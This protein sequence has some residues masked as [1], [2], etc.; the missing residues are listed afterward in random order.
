IEA[1]VVNARFIAPFDAE[2]ARELAGIPAV[3]LEDHQISGGL[4]AALDETLGG[5]PHAPVLRCGWDN[6]D[7]I[8][9]GNVGE[10]K[11]RYRLDAVGVAARIRDFLDKLSE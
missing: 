3:A 7:A 11:K 5:T 10:I 4:G 1:T 2:R 8:P 6:R 9:H